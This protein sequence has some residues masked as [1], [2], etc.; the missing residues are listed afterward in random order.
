MKIRTILLLVLALAAAALA[1]MPSLA[2]SL[3]RPAADPAAP[4][5]FA[6]PINGGCYIAAPNQ[7]RLHVDPFTVNIA[8][9]QRL[10]ALR[11]QANGVTIYDFATDVSNPPPASGTTYSPSLVMQD[12]AAE[13]GKTYTLNILGK[14][15]GDANFL[16]MGQTAAFTCPAGAP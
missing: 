13:C 2:E 11:L 3:M 5:V 14:D 1:V 12:F 4:E 6:S 15:S 8:S 16:N 10:V 9:G 7:C